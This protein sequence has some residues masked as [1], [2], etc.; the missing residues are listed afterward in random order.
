MDLNQKAI[1]I[2]KERASFDNLL[3][4]KGGIHA[5]ALEI[6]KNMATY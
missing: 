5:W 2:L 3:N 1:K 6:D 4:L